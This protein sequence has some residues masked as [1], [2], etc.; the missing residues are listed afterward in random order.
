MFDAHFHIIDPAHPLIPNEG[1]VPEPF[2][3]TDYRQRVAA[4][5]ITGGAVVSGSF[6]G[7]DQG[8]LIA[9]LRR[10]GPGWVGVTQLDPSSS[11]EDIISLDR[12]GVRA[13]R[14]TLARGG[15]LDVNLALRAHDLAGWHTEL[16]VDSANLPELARQLA[17]LPRVSI[18]HLGL[19][20]SGLPQLLDAVDRGIRV[21]ATGFGRLKLDVADTV[22]RIDAVN[23]QA[24]LFGTDLP[25]TRAP[26]AFTAADLDLISDALGDTA[27]QRLSANARIWYRL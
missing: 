10:L 13:V 19:T 14:F 22:R 9:A 17:L 8:Y 6:Q 24:L 1:F 12:A 26:R 18:D 27:L 7:F 5:D 16:Y 20:S 3:V 4:Y 2:T 15:I 23:P 25:G 21:K 11:D